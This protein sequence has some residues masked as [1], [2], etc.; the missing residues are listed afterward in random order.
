MFF[1][2]YYGNCDKYRY[3]QKVVPG[4]ADINVTVLVF[5]CAITQCAFFVCLFYIFITSNYA[6]FAPVQ[7]I[8]K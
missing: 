8:N 7:K 3:C 5:S 4:C 2:Q 6:M 1:S